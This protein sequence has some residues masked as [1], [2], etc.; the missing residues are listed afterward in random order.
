MCSHYHRGE[1]A[2]PRRPCETYRTFCAGFIV[3][4]RLLITALHVVLSNGETLLVTTVE[5]RGKPREMVD[6]RVSK[7]VMDGRNITGDCAHSAVSTNLFIIV[8]LS[9]RLLLHQVHVRTLI[10]CTSKKSIIS[11]SVQKAID[12]A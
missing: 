2:T 8:Q 6:Q 5:I 12:F 4:P 3:A 10:D 9:T 1:T 7:P 11:K